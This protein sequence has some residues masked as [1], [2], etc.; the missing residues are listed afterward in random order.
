MCMCTVCAILMAVVL[1][2]YDGVVVVVG[3]AYDGSAMM[4]V[5]S[6]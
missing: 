1:C 6:K 4:M 3:G 5:M 2:A